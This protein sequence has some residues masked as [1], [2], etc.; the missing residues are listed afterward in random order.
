MRR[1][2]SNPHAVEAVA[3][4]QIPV[5]KRG[6]HIHQYAAEYQN[7]YQQPDRHASFFVKEPDRRILR[8]T[9]VRPLAVQRFHAPEYDKANKRNAQR[10]GHH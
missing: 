1:V 5:H 9:A 2:A 3:V 8:I 6:E 10:R 4:A 7:E